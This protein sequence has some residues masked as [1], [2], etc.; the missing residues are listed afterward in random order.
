ME[1]IYRAKVWERDRGRCHICGQ[2]ADPKEWHL[3]H[4]VPLSRGGE[5]SYRNVAVAHPA[6]NQRKYANVPARLRLEG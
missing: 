4:I 5:H 1:R 2:M 3:E 6:C